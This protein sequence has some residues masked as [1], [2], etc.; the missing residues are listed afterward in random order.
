[1]LATQKLLTDGRLEGEARMDVPGWLLELL[2]G[3][4]LGCILN[5][6]YNCS[7]RYYIRLLSERADWLEGKR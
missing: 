6:A 5:A 2:D 7:T 1:M 3:D 4:D